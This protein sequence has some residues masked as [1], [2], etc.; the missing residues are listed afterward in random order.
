MDLD[1]LH[2]SSNFQ[3]SVS[4]LNMIENYGMNYIGELEY[5]N[6]KSYR[7]S[8]SNIATGSH[9]V[10]PEVNIGQS[11]MGKLTRVVQQQEILICLEG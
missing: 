11:K 5:S 10:L 4:H 3:L 7:R 1:Y 8:Y 6:H 2:A 9:L